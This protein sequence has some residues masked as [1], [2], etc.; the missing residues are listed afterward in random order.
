[1]VAPAD[2]VRIRQALNQ[3]SGAAVK[4]FKSAVG[5][6]VYESGVL[7]PAQLE[8]LLDLI[9]KYGEA[10]AALAADVFTQQAADVGVQPKLELAPGLDR[11][12]TTEHVKALLAN[13]DQQAS[14][15]DIVE[16]LV[17]QPY[18]T[19]IADSAIASGGGWARVPQG[20]TCDFCLMLASRGAIYE[21]KETARGRKG[22]RY[23]RKC[24]CVPFFARDERDYPEGYDPNQLY[25][26]YKAR[27]EADNLIQK[28]REAEPEITA[29]LA[30]T[31]E[32]SG[33]TMVGLRYKFKTRASLTDK[34]L[35]D[36]AS[37]GL[38]PSEAA[39]NIR[40]VLRYTFEIPDDTYSG[41]VEATRKALAKQGD[42]VSAFKNF[43]QGPP[44][45]YRG[46]NVQ[47]LSKSGQPFELQFHT[48]RSFKV[49]QKEVHADYELVR[50]PLTSGAEK[51]AASKRMERAFKTITTPKG[52]ATL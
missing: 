50:D 26:E 6:A 28:A 41:A 14:V 45:G 10:S 44:G 36:C 12:S 38:T 27:R 22:K 30:K 31:A 17:K 51:A 49:K 13:P 21:S 9:E 2:I 35:R 33:A 19:T 29:R 1:M 4:D 8:L 48:P 32:K 34:I 40:D 11:A 23:H 25:R 52:A 5:K 43:W 15:S 24:D 46:I 47:M 39:G 20:K 37:G 3:L 42:K 16:W 18:R 7:T